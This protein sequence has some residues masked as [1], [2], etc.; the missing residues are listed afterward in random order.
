M[1]VEKTRIEE[2]EDGLR[3]AAEALDS[4]WAAVGDSLISRSLGGHGV[5]E[6]YA[7]GVASDA[8]AAM[9]RAR[10]LVGWQPSA[11]ERRRRGF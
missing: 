1:T 3:Q 11:N 5:T 9:E 10:E 4:V 7:Q 6:A 8:K 2:L